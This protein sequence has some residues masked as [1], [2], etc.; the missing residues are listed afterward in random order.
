MSIKNIPQC[1]TGTHTQGGTSWDQGD[2]PERFLLQAGPCYLPIPMGT[3]PAMCQR[4]C[5]PSP[6][7]G[8][9]TTLGFFVA[10]ATGSLKARE[11][12]A[13]SSTSRQVSQVR[14]LL[15]SGYLVTKIPSSIW[16]FKQVGS[17]PDFSA[18]SPPHRLSLG[19]TCI[20]NC[21]PSVF[22]TYQGTQ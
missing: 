10:R 17:L 1:L 14:L 13:L 22:H 16:I 12:L 18:R 8:K 6:K 3:T 7:L 2:Q 15:A 20:A 9:A 5:P 19:V 4:A 11:H 21:C